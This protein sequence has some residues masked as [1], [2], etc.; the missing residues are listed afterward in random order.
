MHFV[1]NCI[2]VIGLTIKELGKFC[3]ACDIL[4]QKFGTL[5]QIFKLNQKEKY[6]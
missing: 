6:K 1:A 3:F 5:P 2:F 4:R